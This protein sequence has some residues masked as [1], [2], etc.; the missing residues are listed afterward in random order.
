[1]SHKIITTRGQ[2]G[3]TVDSDNKLTTGTVWKSMDIHPQPEQHPSADAPD[4]SLVDNFTVHSYDPSDDEQVFYP[5]RLPHDY[6]NGSYIHISMSGINMVAAGEADTTVVFN[7]E[8]KLCSLGGVFGFSGTTTATQSS[9]TI[10]ASSAQYT[11]FSTP[12]IILELDAAVAEQ[13][14]LLRIYRDVSEDTYAS[15]FGALCYHTEYQSQV[16]GL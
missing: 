12:E 10:T 11:V 15:A 9:L 8:W 4:V 13:G 6:L 14:L 2:S 3:L 1:M 7:V 16:M 5:I